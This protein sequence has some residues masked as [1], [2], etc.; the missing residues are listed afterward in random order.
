MRIV[1]DH[2]LIAGTRICLRLNA[3]QHAGILRRFTFAAAEILQ[4]RF[5]K[6]ETIHLCAH[7]A[8]IDGLRRLHFEQHAA[9]EIDA[10]IQAVER[11]PEDRDQHQQT[12]ERECVKPHTDE[13]DVGVVGNQLST[14]A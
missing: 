3:D 5:R 1:F 2:G 13:I 12:V 11:Q 7:C 10:V 9:G 6:A 8:D 14:I 4:L